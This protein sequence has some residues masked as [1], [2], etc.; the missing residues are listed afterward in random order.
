MVTAVESNLALQTFAEGEWR[1]PIVKTEATTG[2][3]VPE[4]WQAINAFRAHSEASRLRRW[5]TRSEFRMR[6]LLTHGFLTHL[7]QHVL[8]AGELQQVLDR[9]TAREI[10][11]YSA[12]AEI[13][14][15][16]LK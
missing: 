14:K 9:I 3:G 10:D 1:P 15:R 6:E 5:R 2:R 12:A 11:P 4:L 7:E 16:A 13:L 8:G